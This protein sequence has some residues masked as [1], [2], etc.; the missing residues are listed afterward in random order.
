MWQQKTI[1]LKA[2]TRGF[3]LVTDEIEAALPEIRQYRVGLCH[4]LLLHTSASLTL[5]ENAD[6]AVRHDLEMYINQAVP[7]NADYYLHVFEGADDMPAHIKSSLLG[8]S[9][10]LPLRDG[11]F[12]LGVWQGI[13]LGE[14]R[15]NGG[16]RRLFVTLQGDVYR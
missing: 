13:W 6:P 9:V 11:A 10:M 3:H 2:R 7:E 12:E 16:C 14:H 8:A 5:N 15:N 1:E 4:L